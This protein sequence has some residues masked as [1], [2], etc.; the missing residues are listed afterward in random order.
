[1]ATLQV[2][3][4]RAGGRPAEASVQVQDN[5]FGYYRSTVT[6]AAGTVSFTDV[7]QSTY[8]VTAAS[9]ATDY[10]GNGVATP[11]VTIVVGAGTTPVTLTLPAFGTVTGTLRYAGGAP[12]RNSS[13]QVIE[14]IGAG[15]QGAAYL[16]SDGTYTFYA[17]PVGVPLTLRGRHPGRYQYNSDAIIATLP[18]VSIAADGQVVTQDL[19][20]PPIV[21]ARVT[22]LDA[23]G[24]PFP[25]IRI[26]T[27]E[28]SRPYLPG[29][30]HDQRLRSHRPARSR[31]DRHGA[32]PGSE[33]RHH[34]DRRCG[35]YRRSGRRGDRSGDPADHRRQRHRSGTRLRRRRSDAG[36]GGLHGGPERRRRGLPDLRV[37]RCGRR[38]IASTNLLPGSAGFI[39][40]AYT[41]AY[42]VFVDV[43]GQFESAGVTKT[44]D[45]V[46]PVVKGDIVGTIFAGDGVD[47]VAGCADR[48]QG[49]WMSG[50]PTHRPVRT[51]AS[52]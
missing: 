34:A 15:Y 23:G 21:T 24:A 50:L 20:L 27:S 41:P 52:C 19:T 39:I 43:A 5:Q 3:V 22:V 31:R 10:N 49:R 14:L 4:N 26:Q 6:N 7:P 12:V 46:L 18:G 42:T 25:G 40:R 28:T 17:V 30:R 2:Q 45:V 38:C 51:A 13:Y 47:A 44:A 1:M 9:T 37:C 16:Y 33:H 29:P 35:R 32:G 48:D 36:R 8:T 11:P